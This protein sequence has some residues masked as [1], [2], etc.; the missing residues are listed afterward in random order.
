MEIKR[1][2]AGVL[3]HSVVGRSLHIAYRG[4]IPMGRRRL[5]VPISDPRAAASLFWG[6][7]ESAE[8]R[9]IR[10]WLPPGL[11]VVELGSHLGAVA[12]TILDGQDAGRRLTCV[13][14]NPA[15]LDTLEANLAAFRRS[16]DIEV[17][18]AAIDYS[19]QHDVQVVLRDTPQGG[20][21]GLAEGGV[22]APTVRLRDLAIPRAD[23]PWA[24]VCDIEGGEAAMLLNDTEALSKCAVCIAELHDTTYRGVTYTPAGLAA[25]FE[26]RTALRVSAHD[27]PVFVFVRNA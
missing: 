18:G 20:A 1:V 5:H 27:G 6:I 21:I 16:H 13:E 8:R 3:C 23:R 19:G 25:L 10:R 24:L 2:V 14:S 9:L 11:D 26:A 12:V 7:Y 15:I 4:R 17:L 22:R